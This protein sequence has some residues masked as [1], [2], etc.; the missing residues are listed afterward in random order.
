MNY[1]SKNHS[2]SAKNLAMKNLQSSEF[3]R[4]VEARIEEMVGERS[5]KEPLGDVEKWKKRGKVWKKLEEGGVANY[6]SKLHGFDPK[7][8]NSMV[9]SWKDSRVKVNVVSF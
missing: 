2:N 1:F 3:M 5:R 9:N 7:V 4:I 6:F 8:T